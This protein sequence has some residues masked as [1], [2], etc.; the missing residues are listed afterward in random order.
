M[1][2]RTTQC[3]RMH[4]RQFS[5]DS[6]LVGPTERQFSGNLFAN[7]ATVKSHLI[8]PQR[9]WDL[10]VWLAQSRWLS[11]FCDFDDSSEFPWIS[12]LLHSDK[13]RSPLAIVHEHAP[14]CLVH[15]TTVQLV[16][17]FPKSWSHVLDAVVLYVFFF[18][19]DWLRCHWWVFTKIWRWCQSH[20]GFPAVL[21]ALASASSRTRVSNK[22]RTSNG[23]DSFLAVIRLT[24]L[25]SPSCF[26]WE[27]F[28]VIFLFHY[29][30]RRIW[31]HRVAASCFTEAPFS[32]IIV[33]SSLV[34]H[35]FCSSDEVT[36]LS[37]IL[38]ILPHRA[39]LLVASTCS[40]RDK[41]QLPRKAAGVRFMWSCKPKKVC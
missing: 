26:T 19:A 36:V 32:A 23:L 22:N 21:W 4:V 18:V 33:F 15:W 14:H 9:L 24:A 2:P 35:H 25:G 5:V 40:C 39:S 1:L 17:V 8:L 12:H 41:M 20:C 7:S 11:V 28:H 13:M 29:S 38:P 6:P 16:S 27:T 3:L 31:S 34:I 37:L 30:L 10:E